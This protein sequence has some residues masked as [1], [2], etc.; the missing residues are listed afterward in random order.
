MLQPRP[1]RCKRLQQGPQ[2]MDE[3]AAV[4][5]NLVA[6]TPMGRLITTEDVVGA[7]VFL[8]E[9]QGMNGINLN[10]DGGWRLT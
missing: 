10:I 8:L 2:W 4:L 6:R 1:R 3:R 7:C 5:D 9:N